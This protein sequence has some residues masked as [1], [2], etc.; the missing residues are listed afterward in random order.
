[1]KILFVCTGNICRSPLAEGILRSKIIKYHISAEVDSCG[2]ESF[3][4]GDSPDPRA[5]YVAKKNGIDISSHRA[6]LFSMDD[7][8][9]FDLIY[10][11]DNSHYQRL[12]HLLR[13]INDGLKVDFIMNSIYPGSNFN[14]DDPWYSDFSAFEKIF[15]Q[16]DLACQSIAD[17]LREKSPEI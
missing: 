8:D 3:H 5:Q 6:R 2:F 17:Q 9:N 16:L 14:V 13:N 12:K 1:M 11:M 15:H 4:I 7:F 10:V